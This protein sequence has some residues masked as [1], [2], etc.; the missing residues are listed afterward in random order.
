MF[1]II[2][3]RKR[4]SEEKYE[5]PLIWGKAG[6]YGKIIII[7]ILFIMSLGVKDFRIGFYM[8]AGI[9]ISIILS[10]KL[11]IKQENIKN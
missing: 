4:S 7:L 9:T 8:A 10:Y 11:Y 2:W 1:Y 5:S 3:Q 6:A